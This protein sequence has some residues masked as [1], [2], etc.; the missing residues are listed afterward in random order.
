MVTIIPKQS[1]NEQ[2]YQ[3]RTIRIFV[4]S[5]FDDMM[6]ERDVLVKEVFPQ[7]RRL[8]IER[9]VVFIDVDLRWGITKG[10]VKAGQLLPLCLAEIERCN[11]FIGLLGD[12]YGSTFPNL[13]KFKSKYSWINQ[14]PKGTSLT[15]LEILF[16]V[17]NK[18]KEV[19]NAFFYFR[20]SKCN[21]MRAHAP[22]DVVSSI[23]SVNLDR[24]IDLKSRICEAHQ[25]GRLSEPPRDYDNPEKLAMIILDDFTKLINRLYPREKVP[26]EEEQ[27]T[28]A[29]EAHACAKRFAYV[30]LPNTL[31][32]LD[33]YT[34]SSKQ[35]PMV[36]TGE[37]GYGKTTLLAE[38]SSRQREATH[39]NSDIVFF[40]HYFGSTPKSTQAISCIHRLLLLIHRHYNLKEKIPSEPQQMKETLVRWLR[41]IPPSSRLIVVLDGLDKIHGT[42]EDQC[43]NWLP[44]SLPAHVRIVCSSLPSPAL[45]AARARGWAEFQ[46]RSLKTEERLRVIDNYLKEWGKKL[47]L[48]LE[49]RLS[50]TY[51]AKS[52]LFLRTVLDELRQFGDYKLL[53]HHLQNYLKAQDLPDLFKK[54][55]IRWE[56]DFEDDSDIVGDTLSFIWASLQ[57]MSEPE[58]LDLLGK[59]GQPFP[60]IKWTPF[61]LAA[62]NCL[63]SRDGFLTLG[64][65]YIREA[66]ETAYMP[67][68]SEKRSI[69]N[70]IANYFAKQDILS[71]EMEK[72]PGEGMLS[73]VSWEQ[74]IGLNARKA[75]ELPWALARAEEWQL[76]SD[77][78]AQRQPFIALWECRRN[79]ALKYWRMIESMTQ[80]RIID[81]YK[82]V[83]AKPNSKDKFTWYVCELLM[84]TG[85]LREATNLCESLLVGFKSDTG[86][87]RNKNSSKLKLI[88]TMTPADQRLDKTIIILAKLLIKSGRPNNA[89]K[90]L[91][92][93]KTERD[94]G[95]SDGKLACLNE[96]YQIDA[97][98]EMKNW[99]EAKNLLSKNEIWLKMYEQEDDLL[100]RYLYHYSRVLIKLGEYDK[101]LEFLIKY[102]SICR[103]HNLLSN[104]VWC[105][106]FQ[107]YILAHRNRFE[108]AL[109]KYKNLEQLYSYVN[110]P[111]Q[112]ASSLQKQANL[113]KK[114]G[115]TDLALKAMEKADQILRDSGILDTLESSLAN[116]DVELTSSTTICDS[117]GGKG[118]VLCPQ[119]MGVNEMCGFCKGTGN[120]NCFLCKGTGYKN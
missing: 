51:L 116:A 4:S 81:A 32:N 29:H 80:I 42:Y 114:I 45:E 77:L 69:R 40:Q 59:K 2:T 43:L 82:Q 50:E 46:L 97:L 56:Q 93:H 101:A 120:V 28:Y 74:V 84:A 90:I 73:L 37:S 71:T 9:A 39:S 33:R 115:Q 78:L 41:Q 17:L 54:V 64:H 5:T 20:N 72:M 3:P 119:C 26:D 83:I 38:W 112:I 47:S 118:T 35:M 27:E 75:D 55:M 31:E 58:L 57:G 88:M 70:H 49:K 60:R 11:F 105:L 16:G 18:Q 19:S 62:E 24:L 66:V 89:L 99:I 1:R 86:S 95:L 21:G 61:Y 76:L 79:M 30:E 14:V 108:D 102:E 13:E 15:E 91:K 111:N 85:Y 63:I 53:E 34:N 92:K 7:L 103:K 8:C 52:P 100:E 107:A 110:N 68:D 113:Y 48:L 44:T 65:Q 106:N 23:A 25:S 104:L 22:A 94:K 67:N 109:K 36:V 96:C 10:Q 12:R 98:I 117:C 6:E 87:T